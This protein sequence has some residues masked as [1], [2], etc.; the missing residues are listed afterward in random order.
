M[1]VEYKTQ[2][3]LEAARERVAR[4]F[5]L[6]PRVV[7]SISGG[8]DSTVLRHL[9][10]EE[11]SRRGRRVELF[12]LDQEAE[13]ASTIEL[14]RTWM[15]DPRVVPR[16]FQ[17]PIYMTNA[18]SHIDYWLYA[19]G[20]GEQWVRDKDP[21]AIHSIDIEYPKRFYDFFE[22]YEKQATEPTAFLIGLRS[23]ESFNRFRAVT[24]RPGFDGIPW[25]TK[26]SSENA[27]R[28]YPLYDWQFGDVWKYIAD[29]RLSYNPHYDRLY[30][31]YGANESKM[32]VSNL[33]HEKAFRC[34]VDLQ[35]FEPD[36]YDRLVKRLGGVHAGALYANEAHVFDARELP[37]A[38]KS[39][40]AYRD[41]LL[42]TTPCDRI[43]RFRRR[44]ARQADDEETARQQVKQ[45]L[46]ND[47]EG[48]VPV[49]R[50][51]ADKLRARWWSE[52]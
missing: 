15:I 4:V 45:I 34:L 11:A 7:V 19:W 50:T 52:L 43:E 47:W 33:I 8:K 9:A 27:F 12:F 32:R 16:W 10:V 25:S 6:F 48:S 13:Y 41:H 20:E 26:T 2:N 29:E 3:V 37:S 46:I 17:V 42:D 39:W 21:L 44:F 14:V 22:W 1:P 38:F 36:T 28:F 30:A 31:K 18:T 49:M 35:E 5:D 23:A 51:K 24:K 40:R